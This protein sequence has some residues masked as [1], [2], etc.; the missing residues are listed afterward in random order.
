MEN[1]KA[2]HPLDR[3]A[4]AV[5]GRS[6]LVKLLRAHGQQVGLT[7]VGNWKFR[8]TPEK[9]CV[10]IEAVT[11]KRVTRQELRPDDWQA[12]WPELAPA[13]SPPEPPAT[14]LAPLPTRQ[15]QPGITALPDRRLQVGV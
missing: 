14:E 11:Q 6:E 4:S 3:A 5:G 13:P 8:V 2:N 7:A 9:A 12:I 10:V 15:Q 1:T